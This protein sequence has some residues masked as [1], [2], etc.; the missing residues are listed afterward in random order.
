MLHVDDIIILF[1]GSY[2][3]YY[4]AI[5]DGLLGVVTSEKCPAGFYCPAKTNYST[6]YPCPLGTFSNTMGLTDDSE[7]DPCTPGMI[8]VIYTVADDMLNLVVDSHHGLYC[9]SRDL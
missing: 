5:S 4:E 7:C 3:D 6:E 8:L 9:Y 2:C 1:I